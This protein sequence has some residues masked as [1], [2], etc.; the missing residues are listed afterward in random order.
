[1]SRTLESVLTS[2][3]TYGFP[4]CSLVVLIFTA[5]LMRLQQP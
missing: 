5:N 2:T 4:S 1:M 3:T